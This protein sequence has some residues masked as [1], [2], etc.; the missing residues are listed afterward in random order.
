MIVFYRNGERTV[1]TGWR[2]WLLTLAAA[3]AMVVTGAL[4]LGFALTAF[5]IFIFAL[6]LAILLGLLASLFQPRR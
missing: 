5:T 4:V 1:I 6:P 3:L 2:A